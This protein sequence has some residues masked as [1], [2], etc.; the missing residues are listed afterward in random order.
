MII[1]LVIHIYFRSQGGHH[2]KPEWYSMHY[3]ICPCFGGV[4]D[5]VPH[6]SRQVETCLSGESLLGL[7]CFYTLSLHLILLVTVMTANSATSHYKGNWDKH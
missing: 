1:R 7:L 2:V 3:C 4:R 5:R 6:L